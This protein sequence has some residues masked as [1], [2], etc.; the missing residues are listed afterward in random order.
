MKR[1]LAALCA[2]L[3]LLPAYALGADTRAFTATDEWTPPEIDPDEA[4]LTAPWLLSLKVA[5][6]EIGY[7]EGPRNKNKYG[8]WYGNAYSSWCSEFVTWCAYQADK[9]YGTKLYQKVY[10]RSGSS[11]KAF[12]W[13]RQRERFITA[14]KSMPIS[15]EKQWLIGS[16]HYIKNNEY[17]PY[18]GDYLLL[19]IYFPQTTTHHVAFVEGVSQNKDGQLV[20]HVIEGNWPDRVKRSTYKLSDGKIFGYCIPVR[21]ANRVVRLY[22]KGDDVLPIQ[23]FLIQKGYLKQKNPRKELDRKGVAA[24]RAYQRAMKL[25]ATGSVDYKT[26]AQMEQDPLFQQALKKY[27]QR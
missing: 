6:G 24:I 18:P 22:D 19:S 2:L 27:P 20:V 14:S 12:E 25:S 5:Q 16:N 23:Y 21:R 7:V 4:I 10:P 15:G 9:R 3:V 1:L 8:A 13:F 11:F 26:R 17:V